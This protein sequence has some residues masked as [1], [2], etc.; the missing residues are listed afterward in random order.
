MTCPHCGSEVPPG[1][2][3][4]AQCGT[5]IEGPENE[6]LST[7]RSVAAPEGCLRVGQFVGGRYKLLANAGSGGMGVVFKAED[8][9]LRRT[10]A[11]KFLPAENRSAPRSK[12]RFLREAQ[13]AAALDHPNICPV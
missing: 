1:S 6:G 2:P 8:T 9:R 13:A 10:V 5:R 11:L 12:A 7:T 3:F 4:C